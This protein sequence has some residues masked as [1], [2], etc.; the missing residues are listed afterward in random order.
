MIAFPVLAVLFIPGIV[1]VFVFMIVFAVLWA[2][3]CPIWYVAYGKEACQWEIDGPGTWHERYKEYP[4]RY[5]F[6]FIA[7]KIAAI[8]TPLEWIVDWKW[9]RQVKRVRESKLHF[10]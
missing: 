5:A 9:W 3:Q 1:G 2:I 4:L 7:E 8:F 10:P 6:E